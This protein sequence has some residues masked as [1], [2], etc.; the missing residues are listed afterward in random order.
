[1]EELIK[2]AHS[3]GVN[4]ILWYS[5]SGHWNDIVQGPVNRMDRPIVRKKWMKWMKE[6]GVDAIKVDF[7][8]ETNKK[9]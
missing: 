2:Y 7:S 8:E 5:S 3:K 1:M 4:P 6:N 9:P